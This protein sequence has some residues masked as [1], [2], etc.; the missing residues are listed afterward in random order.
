MNW[1]NWI[2]QFHRWVSLVFTVAVVLNFAIMAMGQEEYPAW[3]GILTLLPLAL[4][5]L[6]G[7]YLFVLPY[8]AGW[9]GRKPT[10]G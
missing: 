4:L 10:D 5:Q 6:T 9:R 7:M 8:T 2:R 1:S 3:L